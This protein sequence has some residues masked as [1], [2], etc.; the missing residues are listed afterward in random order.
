MRAIKSGQ[1]Q[2]PFSFVYAFVHTLLELPYI[3]T[4]NRCWFG[5]KRSHG[6]QSIVR[7]RTGHDSVGH[8]ES[9]QQLM[10]TKSKKPKKK[11]YFSTTK[12]FL[13]FYSI[14]SISFSTSFWIANFVTTARLLYIFF[15]IYTNCVNACLAAFYIVVTY[16][17]TYVH[18]YV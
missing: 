6:T 13:Y 7:L 18:K 2:P 16:N 3:S 10:K 11:I 9:V 14:L 1:W 15:L 17:H 8:E 12:C 5:S 4:G